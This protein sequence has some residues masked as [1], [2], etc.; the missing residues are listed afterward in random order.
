MLK[1]EFL[2]LRRRIIAKDFERMKRKIYG[3][4]VTEFN[5]VASIS[6][7]FLADTVKQINS[8]DYVD[9]FDNITMDYAKD[10]L[11]ELFVEDK[12][13]LSVIKN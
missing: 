6:K 8:F 7:M 11:N 9:E 1:D 5:D 3:E 4:F 12:I 2:E 13:I 10:I